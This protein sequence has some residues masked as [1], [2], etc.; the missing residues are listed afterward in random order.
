[1][2][3]YYSIKKGILNLIANGKSSG[4]VIESGA[5]NTSVMPVNE[6]YSLSRLYK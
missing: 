6:G 5:Y 1:V 3:A 2:P 4:L